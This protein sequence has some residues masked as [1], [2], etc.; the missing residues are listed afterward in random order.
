VSR[1]PQ[2][3]HGAVDPLQPLIDLSELLG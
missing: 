1:E 3:L 2:A